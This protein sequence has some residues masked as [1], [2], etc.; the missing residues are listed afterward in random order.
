[1]ELIELFDGDSLV[2]RLEESYSNYIEE[3]Y[4]DYPGQRMKFR[5]F[6]E[7][8]ILTVI[9]GD[10]NAFQ[11]LIP[12]NKFVYEDLIETL[13]LLRTFKPIEEGYY[14]YVTYI[15]SMN[16]IYVEREPI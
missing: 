11:L 8:V 3:N 6:V 13:S 16:L 12:E 4:S 9:K 5:K 1:M 14:Y 7:K 15:G 2:M 10:E